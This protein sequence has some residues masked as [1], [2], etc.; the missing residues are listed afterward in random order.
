M[1]TPNAD[2]AT[3]APFAAELDVIQQR[4]QGPPWLQSDSGAVDRARGMERE[5]G[6]QHF[7]AATPLT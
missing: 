7:T 1:T 5:K 2:G 4:F 6:R 3:N